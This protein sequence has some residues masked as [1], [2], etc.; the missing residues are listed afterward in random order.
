MRRR[1]FAR[2]VGA[3]IAGLGITS[4]VSAR[5]DGELP[6]E[7]VSTTRVNPLMQS[8]V[9]VDAG[10]WV[11]HYIGWLDGEGGDI[12]KED[13]E[14]WL[15]VVEMRVWIDGTEL[16]D[17]DDYWGE[18]YY[19]EQYESYVVFWEYSTPP[20]SPGTYSFTIEF[21]YPDG[22]YDGGEVRPPGTVNRFS[23][24]YKVS[25]GQ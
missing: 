15:D 6:N 20:K 2:M 8:P 14:R 19:D 24:N 23:C 12:E 22:F 21:S 9:P 7:K 4:S 17:V 5:G 13:V 18:I 10:D 11:T 3:G 25:P 16:Q 1:Q